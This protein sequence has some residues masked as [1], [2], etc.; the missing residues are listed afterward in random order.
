MTVTHKNTL[1]TGCPVKRVHI[2]FAP[3]SLSRF[4]RKSFLNLTVQNFFEN[5]V[6]ILSAATA[7]IADVTYLTEFLKSLDVLFFN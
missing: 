4:D 1:L 2:S 3:G 7:Y 5:H 6:E